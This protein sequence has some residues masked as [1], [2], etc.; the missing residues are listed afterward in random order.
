MADRAGAPAT[1]TALPSTGPSANRHR[2]AV[3]AG[4]PRLAPK[5]IEIPSGS[6][7]ARSA[8][9]TVHSAAVPQRRPAAAIQT[10]TRW[11]TRPGSTPSPKAS[12]TPAPSWLGIWNSSMGRGVAPA[13]LFQSVGLTPEAWIPDPHLSGARLGTRYVADAQHLGGRARAVVYGGSHA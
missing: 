11:P 4:T 6:R 8:G 13:R 2:C 10:H 3:I 7:T 5:S 1:S 9:T 12:M